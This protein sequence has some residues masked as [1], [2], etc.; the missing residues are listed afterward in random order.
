VNSTS[1]EFSISVL[2]LQ[3]PISSCSLPTFTIAAPNSW[4]LTIYMSSLL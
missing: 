1:R 3:N 2:Q 4:L